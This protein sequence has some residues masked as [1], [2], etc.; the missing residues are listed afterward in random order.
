MAKNTEA[1]VQAAIVEYVRT[2]APDI[3][4][5]HVPNGGLRSKR[6]AAKLRWMGVLPGI[7][8]LIL[9]HR[10]RAIFWEVKPL[11]RGVITEAQHEVGSWLSRNWFEWRIVRSVDDARQALANYG[12]QTREV[13]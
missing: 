12:I 9:L 4:I 7:P 10:G 8:D 11:N 2:V 5:F 13:L 3:L 1:A 6:E